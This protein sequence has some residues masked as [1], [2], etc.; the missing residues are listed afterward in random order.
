MLY[1][2]SAL[3]TRSN[4]HSPGNHQH[5]T[6][7]ICAGFPES[8]PFEW[9]WWSMCARAICG[10]WRKSLFC[11]SWTLPLGLLT[12]DSSR[13]DESW[14]F[15]SLLKGRGVGLHSLLLLWEMKKGTQDF[16]TAW[17]FCKQSTPTSVS[18]LE[19]Q[20][21]CTGFYKIKWNQMHAIAL[22]ARCTSETRSDRVPVSST[23]HPGILQ[24]LL[25]EN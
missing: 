8:L 7:A 19:I 15:V 18:G 10:S 4:S 3:F 24:Y 21:G 5:F 6:R 9:G 12:I 14:D 13:R 17:A 16:L 22:K 20:S 2:F 23:R 25:I 1:F 11:Y